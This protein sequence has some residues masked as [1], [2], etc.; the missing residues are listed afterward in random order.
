ME[1][2]GHVHSAGW[3]A[4]GLVRLGRV[5][6]NELYIEKGKKIYDY[7]RSISTSFGWVPGIC[8]VAPNGGRSTGETCCIKDMMIE[9]AHELIL[10]GYEQY[11]ND[12]NLFARNQLVENQI[13]YT[14][15]VEV[16][17]DLPTKTGPHTEIWTKE[18]WGDLPAARSPIPYPLQ[19][20]VL[21]QAAASVWLPLQ[22]VLCGIMCSART[23]TP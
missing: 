19:S 12:I 1:F 13:M 20:S 11:W 18:L 14:G 2:F 3:V 4:S 8:A 10:C 21:L 22:S 6:G 23:K 15:Y 16:N 9:C 5:T 17:N 7:I